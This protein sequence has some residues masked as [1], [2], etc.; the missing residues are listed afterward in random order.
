MRWRFVRFWN[1]NADRTKRVP[2][3]LRR[4]RNLFDLSKGFWNAII[5]GLFRQ[6][7]RPRVMIRIHFTNGVLL[8]AVL[9]RLAI[10]TERDNPPYQIRGR[11]RPIRREQ[12]CWRE[13]E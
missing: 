3:A 6:Q 1:Q 13:E 10:V 11:S 7:Y 5:V 2:K 12:V 8:R 9:S 4:A